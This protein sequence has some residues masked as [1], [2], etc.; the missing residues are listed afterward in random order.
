[1]KAAVY[2][3]CGPPD[4][5]QIQDVEKPVPKDNEIVGRHQPRARWSA[6]ADDFRTFL[7]NAPAVLNYRFSD[8]AFIES[9]RWGERI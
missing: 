1:M 2:S 7:E 6:L 8:L 3:R 5:V 4:V 9:N